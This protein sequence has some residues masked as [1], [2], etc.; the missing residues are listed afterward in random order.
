MTLLPKSENASESGQALVLV[1]LTLAV[2]LTLVLFV[3]SRS[4]TD[5]SVSTNQEES[6]RAFSAAEAG[7]EKALVVGSG[8]GGSATTIGNASYTSNVTSFAE[9]TQV[10]N[11]PILLSS[12]DT[13]TTWF[14]SHDANNNLV[15]GSS[16]CFTSTGNTLM[17]VCWGKPGTS[18]SSTT[19]PAI[20]VSVYY[21][22]TPGDPATAKIARAAYDVNAGR[23]A[24]NSFTAG[25][26]S[27]CVLD[28]INYAFQKAILFSDLGIPSS[29]YNAANGLQFAQIKMLYNSDTNHEIG[30]T[31]NYPGNSNLPS[32]GQNI[33]S[34]GTAGSTTVGTGSTR[35]IEVFQ[36]WP[37]A[38]Y[39]FNYVVYGSDKSGGLIKQ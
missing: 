1:L 33:T 31:V 25:N 6:V 28:G 30:I 9:G 38:P 29:V 26:S 21:E 2:V 16:P 27:A 7:V 8:T 24:S 10:F 17:G 3:L 23:R 14:V 20:E 35:R 13:V 34:T 37:E 39:I 12:G 36:G 4:V 19:T 22:S 15:C 32:Q 5:V 18:S 11:Y